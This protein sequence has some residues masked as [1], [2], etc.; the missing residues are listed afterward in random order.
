MIDELE[1]LRNELHQ[2]RGALPSRIDVDPEGL[3]QG[4][5]RRLMRILF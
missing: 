5:N 3:E 2:V 4:K 1:V